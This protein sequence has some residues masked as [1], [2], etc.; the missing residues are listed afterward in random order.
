MS[1]FM[2]SRLQWQ[3][4]W[5]AKKEEF[6]FARLH[7]TPYAPNMA[8]KNVQ[9]RLDEGLKQKA[10]RV[11]DELGLDMPTALRL[12]LKKLVKTRSIPF[13]VSANDDSDDYCPEQTS[14][15]LVAAK[16]ARNSKN[17]I[18]PFDSADDMIASLRK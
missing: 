2:G 11:L 14:E 13:R 17:R 4:G 18:G 12:F 16:E 1:W 10:E 3:K 6:I 15:I 5:A 7:S 9:L 8:I